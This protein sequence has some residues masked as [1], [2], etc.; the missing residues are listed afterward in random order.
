MFGQ[1]EVVGVDAQVGK[2]RHVDGLER[3]P[4]LRLGR[5][6]ARSVSR[7]CQPAVRHHAVDANV[8]AVGLLGGT[9]L[10]RERGGGWRVTALE[11]VLTARGR[12]CAC[13]DSACA[14]RPRST[15]PTG[16]E[17]TSIIRGAAPG[18]RAL[19]VIAIPH[20]RGGVGLRQWALQR[21]D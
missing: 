5:G 20:G 10:G 21:P 2:L 17:P 3:L 18:S 8:E 14:D 9:L 11:G 6:K 19:G 1:I 16:V 12:P 13:A 15:S 7:T 4:R